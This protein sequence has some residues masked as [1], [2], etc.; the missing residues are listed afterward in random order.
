MGEPRPFAIRAWETRLLSASST[1][2]GLLVLVL[3][4]GSSP[5][6]SSQ[7]RLEEVLYGLRALAH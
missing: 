7:E 6:N 5:G 3:Q 4:G 1:P 2:L